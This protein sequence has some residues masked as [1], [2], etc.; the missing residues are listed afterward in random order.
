MSQ[1]HCISDTSINFVT[2]KRKVCRLFSGSIK[3]KSSGV[4]SK[5][6][7]K[8]VELV[9][10]EKKINENVTG[11]RYEMR[12]YRNKLK[13]PASLYSLKINPMKLSFYEKDSKSKKHP[14]TLSQYICSSLEYFNKC[15]HSFVCSSQ[16]ISISFSAHTAYE[17]SAWLS[18]LQQLKWQNE[19]SLS[20]NQAEIE[21]SFSNTTPLNSVN[22]E[23][24][25]R[26][27]FFDYYSGT[28]T[29]TKEFDDECLEYM[30]SQIKNMCIDDDDCGD[31]T[32]N[33]FICED[34]LLW[35]RQNDKHCECECDICSSPKNTIL[36]ILSQ[37][38]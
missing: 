22:L 17:R 3:A 16:G 26:P 37:L 14:F 31:E 9:Y 20:T 25:E 10:V 21:H 33:K 27:Q 28:I 32:E 23:S 6:Q 2:A 4:F 12:L 15:T 35:R 5:F 30:E 36:G 34:S 8:Y 38:Q 1:L 19:P 7:K 13:N 24:N 29:E 11:G 18:V